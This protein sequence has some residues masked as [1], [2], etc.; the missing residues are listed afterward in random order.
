M[1]KAEKTQQHCPGFSLISQSSIIQGAEHIIYSSAHRLEGFWLHHIV[2]YFEDWFG[3]LHAHC[4]GQGDTPSPTISQ[5][6]T[7]LYKN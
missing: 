7:E 6:N 5:T 3:N 4:R 1:E 2:S